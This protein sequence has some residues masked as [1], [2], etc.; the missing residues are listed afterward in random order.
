MYSWQWANIKNNKKDFPYNPPLFVRIILTIGK[1][2]LRIV[3]LLFFWFSLISEAQRSIGPIP[4]IIYYSAV[5]AIFLFYTLKVSFW[6]FKKRPI[7]ISPYIAEFVL[8]GI[9]IA[10]VGMFRQQGLCYQ[11]MTYFDEAHFFN[12]TIKKEFVSKKSKEEI[13][14]TSSKYIQYTSVEHFK[15]AN[16][17]CCSVG[18]RSLNMFPFYN[19]SNSFIVGVSFHYLRYHKDMGEKE[20]KYLETWDV[21]AC[22][23]KVGDSWA[24]W[25]H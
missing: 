19:F 24:G 17:N 13:A 5:S 25:S 22:G 1:W 20:L 7:L 21:N 3:V 6:F 14:K 23:R 9:L 11:T 16:P 10:A 4:L 2:L 18:L 8:M 15:K 12:E